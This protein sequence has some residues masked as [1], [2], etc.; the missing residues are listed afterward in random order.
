MR[1]PHPRG[2]C[3]MAGGRFSLSADGIAGRVIDDVSTVAAARGHGHA[4]A[5]MQWVIGEAQRRNCEA[6]HLDSGIGSD[7][8]V[9]AS[10][11]IISCPM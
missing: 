4:D 11:V 2:N 9:G 6:V 1:P 5:L 3:L 10:R 7:S 8:R